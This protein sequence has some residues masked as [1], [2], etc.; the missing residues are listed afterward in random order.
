MR[1]HI[2]AMAPMTYGDVL[3]ENIRAARSRKRLGQADV[4]VRMRA[5]GHDAWHRQTMGKVERGER[6][7]T[8]EE[9]LGLAYALETSIAALMMPAE[10]AKRVQFPG[11]EVSVMSVRYSVVGVTDEAIRWKG[12]IPEYLGPDRRSALRMPAWGYEMGVMQTPGF[13][14]LPP[15]GGDPE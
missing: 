14:P 13:A 7:V 8:G 9:I 10:E 5:L 4:V 2:W 15:D 1:V 12:N 6:R 11:G 3:A